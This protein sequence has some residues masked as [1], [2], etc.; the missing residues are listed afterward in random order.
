[1]ALLF[2]QKMKYDL[3]QKKKD[4]LKD[5]ISCFSGQVD[6][7]PENYNTALYSKMKDYLSRKYDIGL[8]VLRN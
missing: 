6:I 4:S 2:G 5:Y 7:Y 8:K 3:P 1:M